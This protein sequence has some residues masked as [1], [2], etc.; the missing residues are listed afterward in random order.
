LQLGTYINSNGPAP[1]YLQDFPGVKDVE[2]NGVQLASG[3]VFS[4]TVTET[5]TAKY[6]VPG[7]NFIGTT[8]L[9]L[10]LIVN[11]DGSA[12]TVYFDNIRVVPEPTA[13]L[14]LGFAAP[15]VVA[16]RRRRS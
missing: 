4:G 12:A 16:L 6:G 11:G 5:V 10:G 13:L 1:N 8:F 3:E 2:L 15:A 9:R 14:L 7:A